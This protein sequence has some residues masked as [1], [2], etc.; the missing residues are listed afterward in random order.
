MLFCKLNLCYYVI[1]N[2]TNTAV[3]TLTVTAKAFSAWNVME[4][5]FGT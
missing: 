1:I 4:S 2:K 3:T 5:T